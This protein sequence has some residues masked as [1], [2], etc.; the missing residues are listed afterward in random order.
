MENEGG[1]H[2]NKLYQEHCDKLHQLVKQQKV[3]FRGETPFVDERQEE[4]LATVKHPKEIFFL[5]NARDEREPY[6]FIKRDSLY[7]AGVVSK[8]HIKEMNLVHRERDDELVLH[9]K[10]S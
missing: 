10:Y 6:Q 5:Y 2:K 7:L 3:V 8:W 4:S 9:G 1:C